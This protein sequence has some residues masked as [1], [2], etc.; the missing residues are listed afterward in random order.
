MLLTSGD[1]AFQLEMTEATHLTRQVECYARVAGD[2]KSVVFAA[3]GGIA[4]LTHAS[5]GRRFNHVAGFAMRTPACPDELQA[6]EQRYADRG[7][8]VEIDLCPHADQTALRALSARGYTIRDFTNVY[9][10]ALSDFEPSYALDSAIEVRMAAQQ[11]EVGAAAPRSGVMFDENQ[12]V[13][14]SVAASADPLRSRPRAIV[15]SLA[16]I[17]RARADTLLFS[18]WIDE[19]VAGTA[20][21]SLIDSPFG[22]VAQLCLACTLP[23][24]RGRGVYGALLDARLAAARDEGYEI[25]C[26]TLDAT[27]RSAQC[28]ERAGFQLAYTR[29]TFVRFPSVQTDA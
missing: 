9:A 18:A 3:A 2:T 6:L 23:A 24:F 17:A 8:P 19:Q 13:A 7:L 26:V 5:L 25:A 14:Q 29:P 28:V 27:E 15:E 21:L 16:K 11:D 22:R 12:F 10:C 1:T 20:T 4:A